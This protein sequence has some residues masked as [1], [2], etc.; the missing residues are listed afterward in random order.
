LKNFLFFFLG[1]EGL[2]LNR[3]VFNGKTQAVFIVEMSFGGIFKDMRVTLGVNNLK[4]SQL[5]LAN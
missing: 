3:L 1:G 2:T 4:L 5:G